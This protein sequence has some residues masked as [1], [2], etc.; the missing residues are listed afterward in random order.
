[1]AL[2]PRLWL[3]DGTH[4]LPPPSLSLGGPPAGPATAA[5]RP[6]PS[7]ITPV[8]RIRRRALWRGEAGLPDKSVLVEWFPAAELERERA[9]ARRV[10]GLCHV[11]LL[12][13][14]DIGAA[15]PR[16]AYA[17]CEAPE[18]VDLFTVLR[19]APGELPAW[20]GVGVAQ[21][22]ARALLA[23]ER[24]QSRS[25]QRSCGHGRV[26]LATVFV[27]WDGSVRLLAFSPIS[28][29]G[30]RPEEAIA[31]ELR[32]SDRLLTPAA[33]VF[34]V[35]ALLRDLLPPAALR[36]PALA[37]LLRRCLHTQADRRIAL[38]ALDLALGEQLIE[39]QAP[40]AR[41]SAAGDVLGQSCPRATVDLLDADWGES[42]GDGF[43]ALPP[44]L[45]PLS[46]STVALSPTWLRPTQPQQK[47]RTSVATLASLALP[48]ALGLSAAAATALWG[49]QAP[50]RPPPPPAA[51]VPMVAPP[52]PAAAAPAGLL[53][54]APGAMA[55]AAPELRLT[56]ERLQPTADRLLLLL[57]FTNVGS[58]PIAVE[59]S[60]LRL[61][62]GADDE[63]GLVPLPASPLRIGPGRVQRLQ[64]EFPLPAPKT[65]SAVR[66]LSLRDSA[67]MPK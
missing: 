53:P 29:V 18:G 59:P 45:A 16:N 4:E 1:M 38:R 50:S 15:D 3:P 55:L 41:A 12:R 51:P 46:A 44:T 49:G 30:S 40:L 25:R 32:L 17:V 36:R 14:L 48:V 23:I 63:L 8:Q 43:P 10:H 65:P 2:P 31:P 11:H 57:R 56:L 7:S 33:D 42:T 60:L 58:R 47:K 67:Q 61:L 5:T 66:F 21:A 9:A 35:G 52:A 64:L 19:A 54:L 62:A 26:N 28:S 24:H 39:L 37:R 20:W 6:S 34:A 13:L 27:G 22:V